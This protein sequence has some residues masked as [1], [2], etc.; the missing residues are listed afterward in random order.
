MTKMPDLTGP[1]MD[2]ITAIERK[3]TALWKYAF[4]SVLAVLVVLAGS[5]LTLILWQFEY[6]Q[7]GDMLSIIREDA[8]VFR[9]YWLDV[10]EIL[11]LQTPHGLVYLSAGFVVFA[12]FLVVATGGQRRIIARK[13]AELAKYRAKA[14]NKGVKREEQ[15]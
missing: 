9:E 4:G 1:V 13:T 3:R 6:L 8:E 2:R 5:A 7:S 14:N 10:L 15:S 11:W 12:V